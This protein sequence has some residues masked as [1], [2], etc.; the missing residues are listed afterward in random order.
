[1]KEGLFFDEEQVKT[2]NNAPFPVQYAILSIA[3]LGANFG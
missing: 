2:S 1:V 3:S